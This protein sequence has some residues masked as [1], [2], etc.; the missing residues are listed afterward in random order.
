MIPS[1]ARGARYTG[2]AM[3]VEREER[4]WLRDRSDAYV[5]EVYSQLHRLAEQ[6]F[7][8]QPAD[9][10]LQPTAL[11]HEAYL[12]L[13]SQPDQDWRSRSHFYAV[14]AR[15]MRQILVDHARRRNSHKRGRRWTRVSLGD[16][17]RENTSREVDLDALG[18]ALSRLA[19]LSE[20]QCR[21][22]ELRFLAGLTI[23]QTASILAVSERTV[24]LDWRMARAWLIG[25]LRDGGAS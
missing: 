3:E 4:S 14:A 1:A 19:E 7:L 12:R 9:H 11:I 2:R 8:E 18:D 20:R 17:M 6:C 21:I 16:S 5:D 10:T 25:E 15:A 24:K 22:V 13:I 23:A